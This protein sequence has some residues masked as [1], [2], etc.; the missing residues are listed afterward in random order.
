VSS[1]ILLLLEVLNKVSWFVGD[2]AV[3]RLVLSRGGKIFFWDL[4]SELSFLILEEER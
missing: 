2:C 3:R 1:L 4:P